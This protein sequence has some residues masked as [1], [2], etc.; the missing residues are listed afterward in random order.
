MQD[1]G[2]KKKCVISPSRLGGVGVPYE[3]SLH[4]LKNRAFTDVHRS[5]KSVQFYFKLVIIPTN[6]TEKTFRLVVVDR[7]LGFPL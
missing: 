6:G 3:L 7:F 5:P 1:A 4:S 2:E